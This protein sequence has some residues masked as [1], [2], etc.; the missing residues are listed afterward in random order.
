MRILSGPSTICWKDY[1]F[2]LDGLGILVKNQLTVDGCMDSQCHSIDLYIYS[3]IST[4]LSWLR[5]L[6]SKFW[7]SGN[8]SP[9][10]FFFKITLVWILESPYEFYDQFIGF[11]KESC[12]GFHVDCVE[13]VDQFGEENRLGHPSDPWQQDTFPCI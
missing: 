12:W 5:L 7:N 3:C 9:T 1:S 13:Q 6:C 4:T 11:Y 10:L 8:V 2:P